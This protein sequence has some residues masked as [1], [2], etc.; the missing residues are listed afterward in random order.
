MRTHELFQKGYYLWLLQSCCGRSE[1]SQEVGGF[2]YQFYEEFDGM[3]GKRLRQFWESDC[4]KCDIMPFFKVYQII[5]VWIIQGPYMMDQFTLL[6]YF[7]K[8]II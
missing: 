1:E 3:I 4:I 5:T 8:D 6:I 7:I 2:L